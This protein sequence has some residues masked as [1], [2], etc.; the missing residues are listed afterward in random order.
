MIQFKSFTNSEDMNS[1]LNNGSVIPCSIS[2]IGSA[3]LIG[4]KSGQ[5]T[6]NYKVENLNLGIVDSVDEIGTVVEVALDKFTN[7]VSQSVELE[8]A[9]VSLTALIE[10]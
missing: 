3:I 8:G 9:N 10:E 1:F 7:V 2:T 4:F 6:K 5:N